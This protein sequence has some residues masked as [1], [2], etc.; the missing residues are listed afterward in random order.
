MLLKTVPDA[1]GPALL[2]I[3]LIEMIDL[4]VGLPA[5]FLTRLS[6]KVNIAVASG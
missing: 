4:S 2:R 3:S 1:A 6:L 5:N